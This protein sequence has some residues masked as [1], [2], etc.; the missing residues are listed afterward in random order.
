PPGGVTGS[1][2]PTPYTP[3]ARPDSWKAPDGLHIPGLVLDAVPDAPTAARVVGTPVSLVDIAPTVLE[4]TGNTCTHCDGRSLVPAL[5]GEPF[6]DVAVYAET[7]APYYHYGWAPQFVAIHGQKLLLRDL[8]D[9][10]FDLQ[11][12]PWW[13]TPLQQP[14]DESLLKAVDTYSAGWTEPGGP[15]DATTA[16]A[17]KALNYTTSRVTIDGAPT[18]SARA[19]IGLMHRMFLAQGRMASE[20]KRAL[21]ELEALVVQAPDLVDAWFTIGTMRWGNKDFEGAIAALDQ[22]IERS[23]DHPL[24]H[25]N[26]LYILRE[27]GQDD[28]ALQYA[29]ELAHSNPQDGRW[30]RHRVDMLGRKEQ[31]KLVQEACEQGLAMIPN[32]PFLEYM[33]G[34][35]RLQ[36]DDP[37]GGLQALTASKKHGTRANDVDLWIGQANERLGDIDAAVAAYRDQANR[38]PADLRPAVA[39]AKL[40]AKHDRCIDALP[41]LL[42]AI[43]RGVKDPSIHELYKVCGGL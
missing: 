33:L 31:P 16:A 37:K 20:P 39:A 15:V 40:L 34:L 24:A 6:P 10:T 35:A 32:D 38:T 18:D 22:V 11:T 14:S 19:H 43:Q 21:S 9:Q 25:N 36:N 13:Q 27:T 8:S 3:P 1:E 12:D 17:L 42:T 26:K 23:P 7:A 28:R 30:H 5:R 41:Y 2:S 4:L 29:T